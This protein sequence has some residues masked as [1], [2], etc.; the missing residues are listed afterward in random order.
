MSELSPTLSRLFSIWIRSGDWSVRTTD[1]YRSVVGRFVAYLG[2]DQRRVSTLRPYHIS[3]WAADCVFDEAANAGQP[4]APSTRA[5]MVKAVNA[6]LS[7]VHD[8]GETDVNL[9]QAVTAPSVSIVD[10]RA[11][12]WTPAESD[13][14][15]AYAE[16]RTTLRGR[17]LRDLALWLLAYDTG[18]RAGSLAGVQRQHVDMT[19]RV[20]RL[21]NTKTSRWYRTTFGRYT[22]DVVGEL[23]GGLPGDPAVYLFNSRQ[24]GRPISSASISQTTK[25]AR[26]AGLKVS[27]KSIHAWRHLLAVRMA[28]AGATTAQIAAALDDHEDTV[29]QHYAAEDIHSAAALVAS[30]AYVPGKVLPFTG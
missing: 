1:I 6:F 7:W 25:R 8:Q 15:L 2:G 20:V 10:A 17:H 16:G 3:E 22:S 4:Y 11:K 28:E 29:R 21:R 30:V 26:Q 9:S 19:A 12:A 5:S 18:A 13:L 23:L 27:A 24:P 14:L